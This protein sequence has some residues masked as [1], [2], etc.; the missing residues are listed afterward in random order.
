[1]R[2]NIRNMIWLIFRLKTDALPYSEIFV[3]ATYEKSSRLMNLLIP[4]EKIQ[5]YLICTY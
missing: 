4:D 5:L 2:C 3:R 1:M